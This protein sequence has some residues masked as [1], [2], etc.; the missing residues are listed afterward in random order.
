MSLR[1]RT[2]RT[3]RHRD[4]LLAGGPPDVWR[5]VRKTFN[6]WAGRLMAGRLR[7]QAELLGH[8]IGSGDTV[9]DVGCGTGQLGNYVAEMHGAIVTGIDVH[10]ARSVP[11]AFTIFDG[12]SIPF[13][14]KAFDHVLLSFVLHHAKDPMALIKECHRVARHTVIAFEDL[15]ESRFERLSTSVHVRLFNL[16]WRLE[17]GGDYRAALRWLGDTAAT[18]VHTA[19]PRLDWQ[20]SIYRVPHAMLAY[21][22]LD[23]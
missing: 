18:V 17:R 4:T 6:Q 9:L 23:A 13:D 15:P 20:D 8:H 10:D 7:I 12:T 5:R 14:D 16:I 2:S 19:L 1:Q 11:I 22:L 3:K 21:R